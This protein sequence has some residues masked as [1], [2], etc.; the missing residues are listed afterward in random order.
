M[1]LLAWDSE[2]TLFAL[3]GKVRTQ[4]QVTDLV[5]VSYA[6]DD[7]SGVLLADQLDEFLE[8][9]E[10]EEW[11]LVLHNAPF[12]LAVLA[13]AGLDLKSW[14][15]AAR[16]LDT[17]VLYHNR[18]PLR[19]RPRALSAIHEH[20]FGQ[21]LDKGSIRTSFTPGV[22]LT[23][24][25]TQ[26][27]LQDAQATLA[28]AQRLLEIP[29]GGLADSNYQLEID[30]S[31]RAERGY[32]G[33]PPDFLYS[34]ATALLAWHLEP[35]GLL[36]DTGALEELYA[37][38]TAEQ[39]RHLEAL[40]HHGFVAAVRD[41]AGPVERLPLAYSDHLGRARTWYFEGRAMLRRAGSRAAGYWTER[42]PVKWKTKTK[43]LRQAYQKVALDLGLDAPRSPTGLLSLEYDYWRQH[44]DGLSP[45]LQAHLAYGKATKVLTSFLNP[46]KEASQ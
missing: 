5:C 32:L 22:P 2:T 35:R 3:T 11:T 14:V 45:G 26:Y 9:L 40:R 21:P 1:K 29:L 46:L 24:D 20:L 6:H 37:E 12:D 28:V 27:A 13:K 42:A 19:D 25:Q 17:R 4:F 41:L 23:R 36:V 18:Y 15:L 30:A 43:E 10:R 7:E 44:R 38:Y 39:E 8:L 16:V 31:G 34:Q 33:T